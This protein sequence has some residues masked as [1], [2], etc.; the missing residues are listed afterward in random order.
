MSG[1]V[2]QTAWGGILATPSGHVGRK[3]LAAHVTLHHSEAMAAAHGK[4]AKCPFAT[5]REMGLLRGLGRR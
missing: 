5:L 3:M 4:K 1:Y 2:L